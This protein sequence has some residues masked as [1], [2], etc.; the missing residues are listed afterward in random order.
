MVLY[1]QQPDKVKGVYFY[2]DRLKD[3]R[4]D[5]QINGGRTLALEQYDDAGQITASFEGE[6][7]AVDPRRE[8]H[9]ELN[10]DVITGTWRAADSKRELS[11]YL[12]LSS[13][14]YDVAPGHLYEGAG[15]HDDELINNAA[16]KYRAAVIGNDRKTVADLIN[17]PINVSVGGR[18]IRI[19]N[20]HEL[21][22][23]YQEIFT[24][25]YRAAIRQ[26]VPRAMFSNYQGIMLGDGEA[27]FGPDGKVK[28]INPVLPVTSGDR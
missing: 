15:A 24:P 12:R 19:R 21:S 16:L 26:S 25:E 20:R 22:L 10:C 7:P 9:G 18:V 28:A 5:G 2:T 6:F 27:W 1:Y 11:F 14:G 8:L 4:I 23:S 17:Y 13:E 3:I